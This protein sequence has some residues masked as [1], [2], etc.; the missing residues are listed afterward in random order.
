MKGLRTA[1]RAKS[2]IIKDLN[3]CPS[4]GA[5]E[6][7]YQRNDDTREVIKH[8]LDIYNKST[9]PVLAHYEKQNKVMHINGSQPVN[10]V[11]GQI[12]SALKEKTGE[13][14]KISV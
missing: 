7:F 9:M 8:R 11:T 12:L 10:K 13:D 14:F 1:E 2:V 3:K 4:C 5:V 6:S